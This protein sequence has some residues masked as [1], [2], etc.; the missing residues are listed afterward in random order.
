[1]STAERVPSAMAGELQTLTFRFESSAE[2]AG[3]PCYGRADG[4]LGAR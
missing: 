1:M 2:L 4:R 3:G